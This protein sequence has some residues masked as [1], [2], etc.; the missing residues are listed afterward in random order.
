MIN[1]P[2]NHCIYMAI[3]YQLSGFL[4]VTSTQRGIQNNRELNRVY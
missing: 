4:L 2:I 1:G 3:N